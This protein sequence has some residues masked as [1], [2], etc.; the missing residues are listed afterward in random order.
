M[1]VRHLHDKIQSPQEKLKRVDKLGNWLPFKVGLL[2]LLLVLPCLFQNL[3]ARDFTASQE[4]IKLTEA[5]HRLSQ[6]Y[7]VFFSYD[8]A[9]I[10]NVEV[11]YQP[12]NYTN[13]SHALDQLLVG[14]VFKYKIFDNRYII[15]YEES[16]EAISSLK[17]MVRHLETVIDSQENPPFKRGYEKP[18][19]LLQHSYQ[20]QISLLAF[21]ISGT[22]TDESGEPLIGVNVQ[23]RGTNKGTS[24]DFEG[25]FTLEDIDEN[26]VLM[27]SYIGYQT[28]EIPVAGQTFLTISMTSDSQ[29]L[30]EVV[31]V[32]YGTQ[33][34]TSLTSAVSSMEGKEVN[35]IPVT[36]LSNAIGG[37]LSGIIVK[38]ASGEPGL[39]GSNIYVR[40]ISTIGSTQPL[41]IVD[42]IPR[43]F[44]NLD[45]STI[46]TF[47]VLKDAAAV[48]PYGVAG[49]NGV[50]L[51][52]TKKGKSG[53][54]VINYNGYV[55]FQNSTKLPDLVNGYEYALLK[56]LAAENVGLAKPWTDDALQ[57]FQDGSDPDRYPPYY[58]VWG[59]LVN[60][61]ALLNYHSIDVSGGSD[62]FNYFVNFGYQNQEGMW[63]STSA[64]RYNLSLSVDGDIT[65]TT[66]LSVK[67]NGFNKYATQPPTDNDNSLGSSTVRVFELIKYAHP[68][69]GPLFYSNGLYGAHSAAAIYGSGYRDRNSLSVY[70]QIALNQEVPFIE[71]LTL[72]GKVA[73]DPSFNTHKKWST[74]LHVANIDVSQ[75]PYVITDAIFGKSNPTL[76]Q[77]EDK[78][79]QLTYQA[80]FNYANRFGDHGIA[81][82]GVFEAINGKGYSLGASRRNY[83]LYI[84]EISMGS[85]SNDDMSTS[86]G[87]YETSQVGLVYRLSYDYNN[88]YLVEASGRYDG[89]YYFAPENRFGFFPAFSVGWR[90]S[91]ENFMKDK[92]L[93]LDNLKV[94]ASYGEVG[95]LAGGPFQ[96]LS[97]YGVRGPGYVIGGNGV[98][99]VYERSEPN[100]NI[101]WERANKT[102]LGL[103]ISLW[104]GSVHF[105]T[106][107]FYEKRSNMLI[108]PN[109][110]TPLEYG[111]G[112]SQV[113][114]AVME[115]KGIE[116]LTGLNHK[117]NKDLSLGLSA[118][119][120]FAK[121]KVLEIYETS[122]T[123]DN[124]NRRRTGRP[125]GTQF[126]YQEVGYF[127]PEDFDMEG[128]LKSGIAI[129][130]WGQVAPGDIRYKDSNGD[131][132]INPDDRVPIGDPPGIIYGFSPNV[133]FK[134]F[135]LDVLFQGVSNTSQYFNGSAMWPFFNGRS[136]YKQNFDYWKEDNTNASFPRLTP[137]P[138][139]N[140][141]QTSSKWMYDVSYLR[142]KSA[143]LSYS[144]PISLIERVGIDRMQVYVSGQNILTWTGSFVGEFYDPESVSSGG[145][146][147]PHQKVISVGLQVTL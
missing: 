96:Y 92:L 15:L 127:Q 125:L 79:F 118:T 134:S 56:N 101:T 117:V 53:S 61:N 6:K 109:V 126:G 75:K 123:Y 103:E 28:Q 31:V 87:S 58:D 146:N 45:P 85:S 67:I 93:W 139:N 52:T 130:P 94:R 46:E 114:E 136:A 41:L 80:G 81:F 86:G 23:V 89:H 70:S 128:N 102:D 50:I 133:K 37:R 14:T 88:K 39:D 55:G 82:T 68:D 143:K 44:Q 110:I 71:G 57:K 43:N 47:T 95:A 99:V 18:I 59:D 105:E 3:Y 27:V 107:Y 122:T 36:D 8:E 91:E 21:S 19:A 119:V 17:G 97:T 54:A 137:V 38:Q 2:F 63:P 10:K 60:K 142:L 72:M 49:A 16:K 120:T 66:N 20:K 62:N 83:S 34:K 12:R 108:T 90:L 4:D 30:D 69:F 98:Q 147:Y 73:F 116:F 35:S 32:G 76:F 100:P 113:N 84:D 104:N 40:G 64:N 135:S 13:V 140:N 7:Q 74:P 132:K 48:A 22:V 42:G 33:K 24:T 51:V 25:N 65:P 77:D 124:P 115:N 138:N 141:T 121:N 106:D 1:K 11:N 129:Q 29:L 5:L 9:S 145:Y 26:S 112:L 78:S 111:V 131:G 144:L